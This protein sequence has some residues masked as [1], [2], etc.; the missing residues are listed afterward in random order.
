MRH[1][2]TLPHAR[3]LCKTCC[4]RNGV[5]NRPRGAQRVFVRCQSLDTTC[6]DSHGLSSVCQLSSRSLAEAPQPGH[7]AATTPCPIGDTGDQRLAASPSAVGPVSRPLP[8]YSAAGSS[9]SQVRKACPAFRVESYLAGIGWHRTWHNVNVCA[10]GLSSSG[11]SARSQLSL[12]PSPFSRTR[13]AT[14]TSPQHS[15]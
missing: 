2:Q 1:D 7:T 14:T 10:E 12:P 11:R 4:V 9:S 3:L 15:E 6:L 8:P 5:Q 13:A